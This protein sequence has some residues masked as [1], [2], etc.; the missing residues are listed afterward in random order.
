MRITVVGTGYVGLVVGTCFAETGH[1]VYCVDKNPSIIDGL[2]AGKIPIFEPGLEELVV[3]NAEEER[4]FFTTDL[5]DSVGRSTIVF[6]CV[7]T[8]ESED[9][10]ADLSQVLAA[11]REV[12]EAAK[13]YI[14]VVSKS[15]C[16]VGTCDTIREILNETTEQEFD[17]VS[18]PEFLKEGAAVDDFLR[19]DRVV[20]G[21]DNVRVEQ[22]MR[23]LYEPFVRTGKPILAMDVRSSEFTK[24]ACN[25]MLASRIS[26]MNEL[27]TLSEALG[28]DIGRVREGMATDTRIGSAFLFPGLGFGGSCFPKDVRALSFLAADAS[29]PSHMVDAIRRVNLEQRQRFI[30]CVRAHY[31]DVK[32]KRIA[33]WGVTFK[34]KTDDLREAP[35]LDVIRALL[36]DGASVV[37]YDPEGMPG[38]QRM[39][40]DTVETAPKNYDVLNGADGL[41]I[42]TEWNEFRRPDFERMAEIMNE[43]VIFDG[44]NLHNPET[45][46]RAGF[47]YYSIGRAAS[48]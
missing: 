20:I 3:R 22:I 35:A 15:T 9:G 25:T 23:E 14:I 43:K 1:T 10:R 38:I 26:M 7:G 41:V 40:G 24:Y 32:G 46:A 39:F 21:T 37:V 34:A 12:G 11:A 16:P 6:L 44:R 30:D 48:G 45:V 42:C 5:A 27:A 33:I 31:G 47:R 36:D 29:K 17:V 28:A 8:P 13:G 2:N 18:N 4:L 19:P